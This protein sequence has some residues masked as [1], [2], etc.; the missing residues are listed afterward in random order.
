MTEEGKDKE[1]KERDKVHMR[2]KERERGMDKRMRLREEVR[3][4]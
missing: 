2:R 4:R 1:S 3:R